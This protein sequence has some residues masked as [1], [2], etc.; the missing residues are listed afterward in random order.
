MRY[1]RLYPPSQCV[2]LSLSITCR[3]VRGYSRCNPDT[4]TRQRWEEG[5]ICI[6]VN[7]PCTCT[8]LGVPLSSI[9]FRQGFIKRWTRWHIYALTMWG[10][11]VSYVL[12]TSHVSEDLFLVYKYS[13]QPHIFFFM[14]IDWLFNLIGNFC[15]WKRRGV[16]L[17]FSR[18]LLDLSACMDNL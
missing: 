4:F 17:S 11:K 18:G 7:I 2:C 1:P 16:V 3:K 15:S 13:Y 12:V 5:S 9:V 14:L 6:N 8:V 10:D